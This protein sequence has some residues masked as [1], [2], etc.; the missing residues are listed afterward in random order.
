ME[1]KKNQL[2]TRAGAQNPTSHVFDSSVFVKNTGKQRRGVNKI[3][4]R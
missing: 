2:L 4:G 3:D 1:L